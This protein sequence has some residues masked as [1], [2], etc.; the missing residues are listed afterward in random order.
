MMKRIGL[1]VNFTRTPVAPHLEGFLSSAAAAG[2]TLFADPSTA[3]RVRG[4]V[5]CA[6]EDFAAQGVEAVLSLGGDGS[7]LS[8]A[9]IVST[10]PLPL[11]GF[12]SGTLGYLTAVNEEGYGE[13]LRALAEGRFE[14]ESRTTL[15]A[16][17]KRSGQILRILHDALNDVVVSRVDG[18]HACTLE[19]E[20]DG[21]LIAHALCDGLIL[22]TPTGSTAYS[23]SVG[24]PVVLS[25]SA[26][27]VLSFIAPH[28]LSTR[29]LVIP[30]SANVLVRVMSEGVTG[31]YVDGQKEAEMG[32][33]D[34]LCVTTS[35]RPVHLIIPHGLNPYTQLSRKLGWG[36][37][38][39]R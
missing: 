26:T 2:L 13:A 35:P 28:A 1:I 32:N 20:I 22:S 10:T 36:A 18:G 16:T 39:I 11:I 27:L 29:P 8:A 4:V 23:L 15:T 6:V 25:S 7:L 34:E 9:H 31:A 33:G 24:G 21:T 5:P 19:L 12:N 3:A 17:H 38:F 37:A 30:D 14:I